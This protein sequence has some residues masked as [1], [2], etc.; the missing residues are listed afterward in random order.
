MTLWVF[1][2]SLKSVATK[3]QEMNKIISICILIALCLFFPPSDS[4]SATQETKSLTQEPSKEPLQL[5]NADFSEL[6]MEK[7][8]MMVNLIGNVSFKHGDLSLKSQ[9][10]VWYRTAGQVVFIDSVRIEDSTQTLLADRVTYYRNSRKVVAD[11]NVE[12]L[13]KKEEAEVKGEHG[14]YDRA[15]KYVLFT[16]SPTLIIKPNKGDSAITVMADSMEYY[17]DEKKGIAKNNVHITKADMTATCDEA[18]WINQEDK[19]ILKGEPEAVKQNDRLTG[20]EMQIILQNDQVKRI[21]VE[22]SAKASHLEITDSLRQAKRE[23]FLGAKNMVFFLQDEKLNQVTASGNAVSTY[24]PKSAKESGKN[25]MQEKNDASGDTI[26]LF[27]LDDRVNQVLIK[28]G[29]MGSYVFPKENIEDSTNAVDTIW[30]SADM[31]DYK[32]RE[33]LITLQGQGKLRYEQVSLSAGKIIYQTEEEIL[34]AERLRIEEGE[35][36]IMEEPPVLKDGKEEIKGERMSYD[37]RSR[38]GKVKAGITSIQGGTYKGE[39]LRKLTDQVILADR[40]TYTTCDKPEPHF[41]F[42]ARRMKIVAKD[43]VIA[44]PVVLYIADL[45]VAAIPYYIFPI[46][47]GRHSGFLTFD[48]GNLEAGQRFIRNLGYYW[49]ASDYWDLKTAFDYYEGSG[50]LIKS[51]ARYAKRY[52]LNG[53]VAGSYNRQSSW[54]L[55]TF[56]KRKHD[57]WDF[58]FSHQHTIS[59]TLSLSASGTFLSDKDYWRDLNLDPQERRNRSLYSQANLSKS[60]GTSG[61][62]FAVDHRWNLDTDDR[63]LSLPVIRFS[64]STLPLFPPKAEE[65]EEGSS[66]S[67]TKRKWYNSIYYSFSS[68]FLNYQNKVKREGYFDRKKFAVSNNFL[69]LSAPQKLFGWLVLNP[70]F[71][72]QETWYYIFKTNFSDS[73]HI[74]GNSSARRGTYS[75]N[76]SANTVLYGTF[77]PKIGKLVGIR[78]VMTPSLSFAWQPEFTRKNEYVS[79][80]GSGGSGSKYKT[81]SF[82]L[83]NILQVKTKSIT[84]GTEVEK[85]LDLFS[86]DFSSGYSFLAKTHKL[87]NLSSV[88]R[89]SAIRNV[90][91]AFSVIHDFYDKEYDLNLLSPR[92]IYFSLDTRL[93]FQGSWKESREKSFQESE[94]GD[95]S[96]LGDYEPE[97]LLERVTQAWSVNINH[98]FSQSRGADKTHWVSVSLRLPLTQKWLLN[99]LNRYDFSENKITEQT[100]ELYRDMHCWE[101]RFTWIAT[102]YRK[103]YYFRINIK[104]LPEV[105]IEKSRGGLRE[106]FF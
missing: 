59:P 75:A 21:E 18:I 43:K 12:L 103:G 22:G 60:W 81:M 54:D 105:K 64:R 17:T 97:G 82:G 99:Y 31:I 65:K 8:N 73:S 100:F 52:V 46:K 23:S 62:T 87:S 33:N 56:S 91:L 51:Q 69:S 4:L 85:K 40:G 83:N 11:G 80:T 9:R 58:T 5:L 28:G 71:Q 36:E 30:Y 19:I 7:D 13:S 104:A 63:T 55:S 24:Y 61:L 78:H 25:M 88:L 70:G 27:L 10:A 76:V 106:M 86:L 3:T 14:E 32:V 44:E 72:Y 66:L 42:Y 48:L 57:R 35:K 34:V 29:A 68:S 94:E 93:S 15:K 1:Q 38:R 67:L 92:W 26:D 50:W 41:H 2:Q 6:R 49:A 95:T 53:N 96:K 47:P 20:E 77:N 98:R 74:P 101:G 89:S 90:D 16:G 79:Y 37:L 39:L 84:D 102:G 45:P